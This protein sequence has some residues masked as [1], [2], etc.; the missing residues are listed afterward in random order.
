QFGTDD[1][2]RGVGIGLNFDVTVGVRDADDARIPTL[3]SRTCRSTGTAVLLVVQEVDALTIAQKQRESGL[4]AR[5]FSTCTEQPRPQLVAALATVIGIVV[6]VD[7]RA[8]AQ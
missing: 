7:A 8:I 6:E 3:S 4:R 2:T 5:G 1:R